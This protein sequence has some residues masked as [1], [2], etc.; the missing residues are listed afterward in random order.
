MNSKKPVKRKNS[1]SG[2]AKIDS[3]LDMIDAVLSGGGQTGDVGWLS[4]SG[5]DA[6]SLLTQNNVLKAGMVLLRKKNSEVCVL[7]RNYVIVRACVHCSCPATD[8]S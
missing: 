3:A 5:T 8:A 6:K 7:I 4:G 1:A 2:D